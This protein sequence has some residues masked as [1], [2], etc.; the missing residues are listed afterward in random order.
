MAS[1]HWLAVGPLSLSGGLVTHFKMCVLLITRLLWME[2]WDRVN[3]FN[4]II[5]V[6]VV[7]PT[8][9][10]KSVRNRCVIEVS[11]EFLC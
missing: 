9:R 3:W 2:G 4:H 1:A 11:V 5:W 10:P 7:S 6:P 8:N